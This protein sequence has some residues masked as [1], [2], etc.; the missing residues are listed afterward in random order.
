MKKVLAL[1]VLAIFS[2]CTAIKREAGYPGGN[3]SYFADKNLVVANT[4]DQR[5]DR[6]LLVLALLAPLAVHTAQNSDDAVASITAIDTVYKKLALSKS[7]VNNCS[8]ASR[9]Q[10]GQVSSV[11]DVKQAYRII[12][13]EFTIKA[14]DDKITVKV[15]GE[16]IA[17]NSG[18]VTWTAKGIKHHFDGKFVVEDRAD[19]TN[20]VTIANIL[21][22]EGKLYSSIASASNPYECKLKPSTT[23]VSTLYSSDISDS[24]FQFET[25]DFEVQRGLFKLARSSADNLGIKVTRDAVRNVSLVSAFQ[26][27][28]KASGVLPVLMNY[29]STYRDISIIYA[30][31]VGTRCL[32]RQATGGSCADLRE[33]FSKGF[34]HKRLSA[35]DLTEFRPIQKLVNIAEEAAKGEAK[36]WTLTEAHIL[37]A[38]RHIDRACAHLQGLAGEETDVK[39]G[40]LTSGTGGDTPSNGRSKFLHAA[41]AKP[42]GS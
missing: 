28:R 30:D 10:N 18:K 13:Q 37:A 9:Y 24:V 33:Y 15:N 22:V 42:S 1:A 26:L 38:V 6:N 21:F 11:L 36:D 35:V 41:I 16:E 32:E 29:L 31:A 3:L 8:F 23:K 2:A 27:L 39:C 17:G 5:V 14:D 7:A 34:Q 12:E 25:Y 40:Q 19:S 4:H 20:D